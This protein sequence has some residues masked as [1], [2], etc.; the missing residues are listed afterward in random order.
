MIAYFLFNFSYRLEIFINNK[1]LD[2][3]LSAHER[4][5]SG[6]SSTS[7]SSSSTSDHSGFESEFIHFNNTSIILEFIC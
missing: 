3:N 4:L 7:S 2:P 6:S 5:L 1:L